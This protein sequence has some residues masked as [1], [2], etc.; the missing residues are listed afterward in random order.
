MYL[1]N[2]RVASRADIYSMLSFQQQRESS[3][4]LL[5]RSFRGGRNFTAL[6]INVL[7]L[8]E[9]TTWL[10]MSSKILEIL[11]LPEG[12]LALL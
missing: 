10:E 5:S 2:L 8:T 4:D 6:A 7:S 9:R 1:F 11:S 3:S 12:E